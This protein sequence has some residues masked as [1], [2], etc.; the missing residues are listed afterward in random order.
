MKRGKAFFLNTVLLTGVSIAL[1]SV[2]LVFHV[3]LSNRIG[4]GGMGLLYLIFSVSGFAAT[5]AI[6]GSRFAVTRLVSEKVGV[7]DWDGAR[8]AVRAASVYAALFGL[9]GTAVLFFSA[10]FIGCRLVGDPRSVL[11]LKVLSLSLPFLSVGA[12]LGG[13]FTAV[14]QPGKSAAAQTVEEL[15]RIGTV[16]LCY[17]YLKSGD[18]EWSCALI[19]AGG[20]LGEITSFLFIWT[21]YLCD[22]HRRKKK[23]RVRSGSVVGRL[24]SIALPLAVTAYA[25]T[26]LSAI[27]NLLVP[28]GLRKSGIASEKAL[29]DYGTIQGMV[30]PVITFPS[31]LFYALAELIVPELTDAQVQGRTADIEQIV[32]RILRLCVMFSAFITAVLFCFSNGFGITLYRDVSVGSYIR[33]LSLLMPVMYMDAVTDGMLRGLNQH[34]YSMK[35][36]VID[37]SISTVLVFLLVPLA[38][39]RGYLFV[40]Y[41][42]EIFNFTLSIRRLAKVTRVRVSIPLLLKAALSGAGAVNFAVLFL[43]LAGFGLT[44]SV[45]SIAAHIL[46]SAALFALLLRL[47]GCTG[48]N[49]AVR[50]AKRLLC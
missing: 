49:S 4:A 41:F 5:F 50:A 21:L 2:G 27:Q 20:V 3:Y 6:S 28:R 16:L 10:E 35:Y 30:F 22:L 32:N 42:S 47:T 44:N 36:N 7:G 43:R 11:A 23:T 33:V 12:V 34:L 46:L 38:A 29:A 13:Y 1:R 14:C 26:A 19:I 25:R 18:V 9:A 31:A 15:T 40:L 24:V 37:S 48:K 8:R 45:F 17:P 39:V